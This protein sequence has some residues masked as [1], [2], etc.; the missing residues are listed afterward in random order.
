MSE[1]DVTRDGSRLIELLERQKSL[2][3]RL[4]LLTERQRA[5]VV[6][7]DAQPLLAVLADRQKI[8]DELLTINEQ[9]AVYRQDWTSIFGGLDEPSRKHVA[10]MLEEANATLGTILQSDSR[11]TAALSARR[12]EIA[13]RMAAVD[14]GSR[15]SA[16]YA[17]A[18]VGSS[19]GVT[20]AQA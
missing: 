6:Q 17:A 13:G 11:D 20:D 18:G 14:S 3:R 5:L 2:Y 9:L 10:E 15:A 12:Q 1:T 4:R 7:D 8:V 19:A 16:A